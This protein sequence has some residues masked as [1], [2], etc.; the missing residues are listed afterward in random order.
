MSM[1]NE[2]VGLP[3]QQNINTLTFINNTAVGYGHDLG[4]QPCKSVLLRNSAL[5]MI[6]GINVINVSVILR[7]CLDQIVKGTAQLPVP[8]ILELWLCPN[9][10]CSIEQS[11]VPL[12][13]MSFESLSGISNSLQAEQSIRCLESSPN[14]TVQISLYGSSAQTE[15]LMV[16]VN[17][18]CVRCVQ[19]QYRVFEQA[20]TGFRTWSCAEC[21]TGQYIIDPEKDSCQNC[22]LGMVTTVIFSPLSPSL[23]LSLSLCS[24]IYC[25]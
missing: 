16:S 12:K 1:M 14:V 7:D 22:P 25:F 23:S 3:L 5:N 15:G 21:R 19:M 17:I 11:L 13:F 10:S 9:A 8:Y 24:Y 6:P 2:T 4:T 18:M 20:V